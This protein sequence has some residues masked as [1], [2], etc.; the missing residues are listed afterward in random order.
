MAEYSPSIALLPENVRLRIASS[1]QITSHEDVIKGLVENALDASARSIAVEVDFAKGYFSVRD[2]GIGIGGAEFTEAGR[3]ARP[4]CTSK[5]N[6]PHPTF[7]RY[8][9]FLSS[10]SYL[11]LLSITSRQQ[12]ELRA[13][14]LILHRGEVISRQLEL[15]RED[16]EIVEHGT[17]VVVHNLFGDVP[18]RSRHTLQRYSSPVEIGKGFDQIKRRLVGYVLAQSGSFD[19]RLCLTNGRRQYTH[20][21]PREAKNGQ[22]TVDATVSTLF[23]AWLLSSPDSTS[24][25]PA[26]IRS[27]EF[28]IHAVFSLEPCPCRDIQY[29]SVG[30]F[31]VTNA[32]GNMALFDAINQTFQHSSF[33]AVVRDGNFRS[34]VPGPSS[35]INRT[36]EVIGNGKGID[37]WPMFYIRVDVMSENL[38]ALMNLDEAPAE[39]C[40]TIS[41]LVTALEVLVSSFLESHGFERYST[42]FRSGT[43]QTSAVRTGRFRGQ[44]PLLRSA[45]QR[46]QIAS[47]AHQLNNWHRVKSGRHS[48]D[49]PLNCGPDMFKGTTKPQTP[50]SSNGEVQLSVDGV[51]EDPADLEKLD[52]TGTENPNEASARLWTNPRNGRIVPLHPRTGAVMPSRSGKIGPPDK[53]SPSDTCSDHSGHVGGR[54][55]PAQAGGGVSAAVQLP[56]QLSKYST[57]RSFRRTEPPIRAFAWT[58]QSMTANGKHGESEECVLSN[59]S[60]GQVTKDSLACSTIIRQV[61]RKFVLAILPATG[62]RSNTSHGKELV[63][64]VD[65]HAADERIRLEDLYRE[66]CHRKRCNLDKPVVFEVGDDEAKLFEERREYFERWCFTYVVVRNHRSI[67]PAAKLNK[68]PSCMISVTTLPTL[69][70]ARC[71]AEPHVL[72]DL[73]RDEVWS[74][75]ASSSRSLWRDVRNEAAHGGCQWVAEIAGCPTGVLEMLK[76]RSCRTAIMFNDDLDLAECGQLVHRLARCA[77]PFQCAHGRPTVTVLGAL[78]GLD[79]DPGS[80]L[81][82]MEPWCG[83]EVGFGAGWK[84]WTAGG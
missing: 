38:Q 4:H 58:Q 56:P 72:V 61:D 50:T 1:Q 84:T 70:A 21:K 63:V 71:Q 51:G 59:A 74:K 23:Q 53:P 65:Q 20:V 44:E 83:D 54:S 35:D 27:S 40:P 45:S 55:K 14:R 11:S 78:G 57:T 52:C 76:S 48:S 66:L 8:G 9:R 29:I 34:H 81:G 19:L 80:G 62:D 31:P 25:R 2:D 79:D 7:G 18:V 75:Q 49:K 46:T 41:R 6:P 36:R 17:T 26:S 22:V 15:G 64:L 16:A 42:R 69:V 82:G 43:S 12:S 47:Q 33:G 39:I 67:Q 13:N 73:L 77:F 28:F 24:W 68:G 32:P 60:N 3:L 30:Q 10:L 5:L 37:R